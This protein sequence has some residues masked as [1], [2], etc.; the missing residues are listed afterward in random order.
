MMTRTIPNS[1]PCAQ[2]GRLTLQAT[3]IAGLLGV[4]VSTALLLGADNALALMGTDPAADELHETA[5]QYLSVRWGG[6]GSWLGLE[7]EQG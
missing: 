5:K 6:L 3:V 7:L 2:A 4:A 1:N